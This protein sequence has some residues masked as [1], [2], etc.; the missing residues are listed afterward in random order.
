MYN[1][2]GKGILSLLFF[3]YMIFSTV[4]LRAQQV[5]KLLLDETVK[6]KSRNIHTPKTAA[7]SVINNKET[8][9]LLIAKNDT[10]FNSI[11]KK[12]T[13]TFITF[14]TLGF[15]KRNQTVKSC[16]PS[17]VSRNEED[18]QRNFLLTHSNVY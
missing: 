10:G 1:T 15:Q 8:D 16:S 18:A 3:I 12:I 11:N 14:D 5:L 6:A 9:T 4:S 13:E 7:M 17:V 2:I